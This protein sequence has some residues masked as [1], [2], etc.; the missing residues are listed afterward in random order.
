MNPAFTI[1][2]AR[3][4]DAG[5]LSELAILTYSAAFGHTFCDTDLTAHLNKHL[6]V[7]RFQ[8]ILVEDVVLVAELGERLIGYAQFGAAKSLSQNGL[9]R[10]LRRLYVHPDNQNLGI[11]SALM[12]AALVHLE[13]ASAPA[14]YLDVWEHNLGAHRFYARYGF[15]L[16]GS[17]K[18]DVESGAETSLDLVMVRGNQQLIP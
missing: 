10:E 13:M 7:E 1:R 18:F 4:E 5:I 17:R 15:E 16:V 8:Q 9:D 3:T 2:N 14:I 6:S 12:N 11:G